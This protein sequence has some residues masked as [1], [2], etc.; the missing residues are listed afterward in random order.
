MPLKSYGVLKGKAIEVRH[1]GATRTVTVADPFA[2]SNQGGVITI[3]DENGL[4]VD[5]L[6]YTR[7]RARHPGWTIV[8]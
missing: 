4:K 2:L 6:S 7:E 1:G 3:L 5:G 8:F